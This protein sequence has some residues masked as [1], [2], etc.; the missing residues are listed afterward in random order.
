MGQKPVQ[1]NGG[2][3]PPV[4]FN[5]QLIFLKP[6][7]NGTKNLICGTPPAKVAVARGRRRAEKTVVDSQP[8]RRRSLIRR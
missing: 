6:N 1:L 5:K 8:M 3:M 4:S 7:I 2:T